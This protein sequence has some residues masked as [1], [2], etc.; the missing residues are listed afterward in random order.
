MNQEQILAVLE[1]VSA[2]AEVAEHE[3]ELPKVF[4]SDIEIYRRL[5]NDEVD[6]ITGGKGS[7]KSATYRM[8]TETRLWD[9]L[10]VIPASNPT[11]SPEFRSLFTGDDTEARLRSIWV[12]YLS[13]LIGNWV[14][15]TYSDFP[16]TRGAV[17]ELREILELMGLRKP[18]SRQSLLDRIR[19]AK[20]VEGGVSGGAA[21]FELGV[22]LKFDLPDG[23]N[24][25]TSGQNVVL[26][27]PDFFGILQR[28]AE[29]LRAHKFRI[30]VAI[31]RL[32]ECFTRNSNA[33][34]R[35]LRALLRAILDCSQAVNYSSTIRVKV[36]LRTDLFTMISQ[37]GAFTNAT[38]LRRNDISW[39]F[40]SM[41]DLISHRLSES[42][43]F[44]QAYLANVPSSDRT[45]ATWDALLPAT[46][47]KRPGRPKEPYSTSQTLC[48]WTSDG[49][50]LYNPRNL[51]SLVNL[52]LLRARENQ[53][54]A[55]SMNRAN[56]TSSPLIGAGE[57]QAAMGELGRRR[58]QDTV[59]NEFPLAFDLAE[60]LRGGPSEYPTRAALASRLGF[61][62]A[63]SPA[64]RSAVDVL[65]LSGVVGTKSGGRYYIPRLYR[66]AVA[67]A[68]PRREASGFLEL[69]DRD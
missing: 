32:D 27:Y 57:L 58:F 8:V 17:D 66:S 35:S 34:R 22:A 41:A 45:R 33:E 4:I 54:R 42:E 49:S 29:V 6:L 40:N 39:T 59:V 62:D 19:A 43:F 50:H 14:V 2:G 3:V 5:V 64:A 38:H 68:A 15:D 53:R 12:V 9:D 67:T 61:H 48:I 36:F 69:D 25:A 28:S 23:T 47:A 31:D 10:H 65:L 60:Q 21:G 56:R 52:A 18:T 44:K 16:T 26:D 24:Q 11:G 1:S 46:R 37:D 13:S 55:L 51:I 30:W 7:G 63:S 20:T